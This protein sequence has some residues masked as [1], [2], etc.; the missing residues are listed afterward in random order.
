MERLT[1][2]DGEFVEWKGRPLYMMGPADIYVMAERLAS[3][4]D[5]GLT[6]EECG[7]YKKFEDEVVASGKTFGR[8]VEL[9]H[10]DKAGRCVVLPCKV[11][12]TVWRI[13]RDKDPH[14]TRDEVRDM[15]FADDMTLC[16]ELVGGRMIFA[17]RFSEN[18][19]LTRE[20]AERAM[21]GKKDG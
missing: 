12:D 13:V 11:Y 7:E 3:Y 5:T 8:L 21:E 19:F 15:Y 20:E 1:A 2:R 9:L 4:E 6:P 16:I 10:A 17:E 14:I 18:A